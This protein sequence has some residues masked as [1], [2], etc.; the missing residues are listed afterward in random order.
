MSIDLSKIGRTMYFTFGRFQPPTRGH[1]E[2]FDAIAKAAGTDDYRIY[3]SQTHD[4]KGDNP[5]PP[6]KKLEWL[7][8][9]FPAHRD[10][11]FS[12]P[13]DPKT[14]LQDINMCVHEKAGVKSSY[15]HVV[16]LVGSDR[17]GAMQWIKKYNDIDYSFLSIEIKSTG[18]RDPDGGTFK[19]S[20]TN[21]RKYAASNQIDLFRKGVPTTLNRYHVESLMKDVKAN[22]PLNYKG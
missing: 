15:D 7:K 13:R 11:F 10:H 18:S 3:I 20:G 9:M 6:D 12:G 21:Q 22:L 2:S 5:L 4:K 8:K 14:C 19:I 17:V 1:G 16:F